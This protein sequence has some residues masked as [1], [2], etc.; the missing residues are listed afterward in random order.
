LGKPVKLETHPLDAVVPTFAALGFSQDLAG[1]FR[2]MIGGINSG[3]VTY[4]GKGAEFQR[5]NVT[6]LE[7][8]KQMVGLSAATRSGGGQD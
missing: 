1:L 3:L 6:A 2:E 5:G 4:E 7:A 8:V